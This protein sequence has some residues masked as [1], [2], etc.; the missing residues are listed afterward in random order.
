[1]GKSRKTIIYDIQSTKR[2][3]LIPIQEIKL[4]PYKLIMAD[5]K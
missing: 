2:Q 1:M 3:A 4:P 5:M